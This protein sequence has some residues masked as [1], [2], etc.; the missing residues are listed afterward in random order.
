MSDH[1]YFWGRDQ[2]GRLRYMPL[3]EEE[4]QYKIAKLTEELK[5]AEQT[6]D[7]PKSEFCFNLITYLSSLRKENTN[8]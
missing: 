3:T 8:D 1:Y 6:K 4:R 2:F 5:R 7:E